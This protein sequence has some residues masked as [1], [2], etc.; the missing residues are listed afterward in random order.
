VRWLAIRS[1]LDSVPAGGAFDSWPNTTYAGECQD[2]TVDLMPISQFGA[3][4]VCGRTVGV[5]DH[6]AWTATVTWTCER[7]L[8]PDDST[9]GISLYNVVG[10]PEGTL[11]SWRLFAE[12]GGS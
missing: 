6:G 11:P 5:A 7:C 4:T 12:A 2:L 3:D 1:D 8:L 10:V 9:R